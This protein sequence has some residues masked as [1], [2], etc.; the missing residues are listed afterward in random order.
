MLE[1]KKLNKTMKTWAKRHG[2]LRDSIIYDIVG[3]H[4]LMEAVETPALRFK[5]IC[6]RH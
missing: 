3:K 5:H 6:K 2:H 4:P 1:W